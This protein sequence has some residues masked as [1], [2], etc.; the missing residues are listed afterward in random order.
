MPMRHHRFPREEPNNAPHHEHR[1]YFVAH[2]SASHHRQGHRTQAATANR[3][4]TRAVSERLKNGVGRSPRVVT[5]RHLLCLR[6]LRSVRY[7]AQALGR[8]PWLA[9]D[10]ARARRLRPRLLITASSCLDSPHEGARNAADSRTRR[11]AWA[12]LAPLTSR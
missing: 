4:L 11:R 12:S 9:L 8:L 10:L 2:I 1:P 5:G 7:P 6:A 3:R